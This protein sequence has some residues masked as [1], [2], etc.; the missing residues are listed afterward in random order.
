MKFSNPKYLFLIG[1]GYVMFLFLLLGLT[2]FFRDT[3]FVFSV[4][5][6]IGN[7]YDFVAAKAIFFLGS[8]IIAITGYGFLW[9]FKCRINPKISMFHYFIILLMPLVVNFEDR[10]GYY[11]LTIGISI[12]IIIIAVLNVVFAIYYKMYDKNKRLEH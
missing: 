6:T 9:M 1:L 8:Q 2:G 4:N 3:D 10:N 5:K 7:A 11:G 12:F